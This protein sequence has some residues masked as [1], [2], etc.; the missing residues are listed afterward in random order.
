[1]NNNDMIKNIGFKACYIR[2]YNF[3]HIAEIPQ[4]AAVEWVKSL[5]RDCNRIKYKSKGP[6]Y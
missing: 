6:H 1:M 3:K 2:D 4:E 5:S